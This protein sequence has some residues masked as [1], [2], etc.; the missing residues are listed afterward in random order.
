MKTYILTVIGATLLSAFAANLAP[1]KWQ[2]YVRIITGLVLIICILS[3]IKALV[4]VDLFENFEIPQYSAA[5]GKTQEELVISELT[6]R[7]E[8]DI[9]ER[10]KK[11]FNITASAQV[12]IDVNSDGEIDGVKEIRVTG[13]VLTAA[14]KARLKEVYG[15]SEVY[16]E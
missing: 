11:E 1:E 5:E 6:D 12:K 9:E 10:L 16:N 3:P 15:V 7:L 8:Q 2:K 13:A 4:S 14:A